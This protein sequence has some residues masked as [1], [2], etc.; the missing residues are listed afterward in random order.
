MI[1]HLPHPRYP[2]KR[3]LD[4]LEHAKN[5]EEEGTG[6]FVLRIHHLS[7][8]RLGIKSLDHIGPR[9]FSQTMMD[10]YRNS[11]SAP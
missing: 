7:Q 6:D 11:A 2:K 9:I 8:Q 10:M 4:Q 5:E 3:Q 1:R